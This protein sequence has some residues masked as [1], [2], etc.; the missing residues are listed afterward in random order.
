MHHDIVVQF[1]GYH[2]IKETN[3]LLQNSEVS[4]INF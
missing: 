2:Y 1:V 4:S 3:L